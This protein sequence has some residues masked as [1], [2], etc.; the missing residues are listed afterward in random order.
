MDVGNDIFEAIDL[1]AE[2]SRAKILVALSDGK[3]LPAGHLARIAGIALPTAS[4]HL[5]RLTERGWIVVEKVGRHRYFRLAPNEELQNAMEALSALTPKPK[6]TSLK[7]SILIPSLRTGRTCYNHLAGILGVSVTDAL[8]HKHVVI[9]DGITFSITHE[10]ELWFSVFGIRLD[11]IRKKRRKFA[12]ICV[13]W[14][15]RRHHIG[16]A[17]GSAI[18]QRFFELAWIE[19][20]ADSRAVKITH[21]GVEGLQSIFGI[22]WTQ[23]E[24]L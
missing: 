9:D 5:R 10:G 11:E 6:I 14:T 19:K 20:A 7:D 15:E 3:S 12:P 18:C 13:D 2:K 16:G 24:T 21:A 23:H 17:L 1:L 4:L 22:E 8:I